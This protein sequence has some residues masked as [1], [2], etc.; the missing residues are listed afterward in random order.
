LTSYHELTPFRFASILQNRFDDLNIS[1]M[2]KAS[3]ESVQK[4]LHEIY[5]SFCGDFPG[6][7]SIR[8][9]YDIYMSV[10]KSDVQDLH[11]EKWEKNQRT[12]DAKFSSIPVDSRMTTWD[13]RPNNNGENLE[14]K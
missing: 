11:Q 9:S 12:L 14:T 7:V 13:N 1:D 6:S 8:E 10:I 2:D 3:I 5:Q 4:D